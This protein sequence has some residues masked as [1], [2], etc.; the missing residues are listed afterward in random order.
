MV[1]FST[2]EGIIELSPYDI[3][4]VRSTLEGCVTIIT[5]KDEHLVTDGHSMDV[6]TLEDT[7]NG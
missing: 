5:K 4:A 1:R 3:L 6:S 7:K 2:H